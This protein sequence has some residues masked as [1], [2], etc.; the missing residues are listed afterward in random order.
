M[1]AK[2]LLTIAAVALVVTG[3]AM[4]S[5]PAA[6]ITLGVVLAVEAERA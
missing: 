1:V 3:V 4:L 6:I 5:L 2:L